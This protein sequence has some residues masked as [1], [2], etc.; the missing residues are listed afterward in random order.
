LLLRLLSFKNPFKEITAFI[1]SLNTVKSN[2]SHVPIINHGWSSFKSEL[3]KSKPK[4][5]VIIPTLN[6]YIYLKDVLEDLEK[7]EYEN[8]DVI[9]IDQSEPFQKEFYNAF[10]LDI[11]LIHQEEK[12]LWLARNTA[13][14]ISDAALLLLIG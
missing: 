4:V 7:Q 1:K 12:A 6:R 3:I 9:I 13:V 10:N 11:K 8:F 14:K 2:L 5:S